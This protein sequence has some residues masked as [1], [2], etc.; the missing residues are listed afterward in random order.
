M[1]KSLT[2]EVVGD[3]RLHCES[4]ELRVKRLLK[5]LAGVGG[6]LSGIAKEKATQFLSAVVGGN[7]MLH[8]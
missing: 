6:P 3:Q 4:C 7:V 1:L 5:G 8:V 2:F